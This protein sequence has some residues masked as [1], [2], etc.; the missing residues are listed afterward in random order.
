[1]EIHFTT[2]L[3]ATFAIAVPVYR[4]LLT[5]LADPCSGLLPASYTTAVRSVF[6]FMPLCL[7]L[8]DVYWLLLPAA[9]F[10]PLL[11]DWSFLISAACCILLLF[12][13]SLD[14]ECWLIPVSS[15]TDACFL[16]FY[17]ILIVARCQLPSSPLLLPTDCCWQTYILSN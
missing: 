2:T 12:L 7:M 8:A 5:N 10:W 4:L 11:T 17:L 9:V 13:E 15:L 1:M 14:A 16:A 6:H 3:N